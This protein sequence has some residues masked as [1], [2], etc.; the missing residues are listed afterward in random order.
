MVL[1]SI[2]TVVATIILAA[3]AISG[4]AS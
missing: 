4:N 2:G 1:G 3:I